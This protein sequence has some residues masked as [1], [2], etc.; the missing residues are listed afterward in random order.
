M[1][2]KILRLQEIHDLTGIPINTLR[3]MRHRGDDV[4]LWMLA[5]RLVAWEDELQDW[6]E[7]QQLKTSNAPAA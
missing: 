5:G 3:Y 1:S 4:P 6:L 2:R 7:R